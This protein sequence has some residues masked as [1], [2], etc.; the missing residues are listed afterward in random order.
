M[1]LFHVPDR[2]LKTLL[3]YIIENIP[4]EKTII[5][6]KFSGY[7]NIKKDTSKLEDFNYTHFWVNHSKEFV[8]S[9]Q[10]FIHTQNIERLWRSL[11]NS[12]SSIKRA[13]E[14]D[15]VDDYL[16]TFILK[17]RLNEQELFEFILK[18]IIMKSEKKTFQ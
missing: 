2:K 13:F 18:A 15:L 5:S 1:A 8:D 3:P 12:I 7:V 6:D 17:T 16:N 10:P 9:T 11:R 4:E 14:P